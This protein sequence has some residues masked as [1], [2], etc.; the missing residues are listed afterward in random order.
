MFRCFFCCSHGVRERLRILFLLK[1]R[2][3]KQ[4]MS[5]PIGAIHRVRFLKSL[6]RR[7][8]ISLP[9]LQFTE[10]QKGAFVRWINQQRGFEFLSGLIQVV[11]QV[12]Q[13]SQKIVHIG[14]T[15][16]HPRGLLEMLASLL[17]LMSPQFL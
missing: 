2:V 5:P 7:G 4:K 15:G 6:T 16:R 12:F 3:C 8:G 14:I 9:Q 17:E 13:H 1:I 10:S 11:L